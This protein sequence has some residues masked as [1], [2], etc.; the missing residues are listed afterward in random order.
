[1]TLED[2]KFIKKIYKL[3]NDVYIL[4]GKLL[5]L[6]L[7]GKKDS[8][9]YKK[10]LMYLDIAIELENKAYA[11]SEQTILKYYNFYKKISSKMVTKP[12]HEF[13][14]ILNANYSDIIFER[15]INRISSIAFSIELNDKPNFGK[16]IDKSKICSLYSLGKYSYEYQYILENELKKDSL[17]SFLCFLNSKIKKENLVL[18][19][20]AFVSVK[21]NTIFSNP[22]IEEDFIKNNFEVENNVYTGSKLIYDLFKL[23]NENYVSIKDSYYIELIAAQTNQLLKISDIDYNDKNKAIASSIKEIFIR[24]NVSLLSKE[25]TCDMEEA[26]NSYITSNN[27]IDNFMFNNISTNMLKNIYKFK[28]EAKDKIFTLSFNI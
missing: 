5:N 8:E 25:A 15:I 1:M 24:S 11:N 19:K 4:Y 3:T 12:I 26:F 9:E 22:D 13:E 6:E 7:S 18:L 14:N 23:K 10:N 20:E 16:E 28:D 2:F 21:Y 17:N 27:N